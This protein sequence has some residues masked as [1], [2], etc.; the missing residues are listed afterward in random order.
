MLIRKIVDYLDV[1]SMF[2]VVLGGIMM[3]IIHQNYIPEIFIAT[4]L[5]SFILFRYDSTSFSYLLHLKFRFR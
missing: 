3:L 5:L 2:S 4:F 1:S